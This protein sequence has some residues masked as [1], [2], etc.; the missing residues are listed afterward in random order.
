M[1]FMDG[2]V[3]AGPGFAY[4]AGQRCDHV[5]GEVSQA[6]HGQRL[7]QRG[8]Q[9]GHLVAAAQGQ[10]LFQLRLRR[11]RRGHVGTGQLAQL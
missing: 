5:D 7:A 10:I 2:Q 1:L 3:A 8:A 6:Q 9:F 4:Q 11:L